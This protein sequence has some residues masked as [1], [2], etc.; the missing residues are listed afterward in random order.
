MGYLEIASAGFIWA[1]TGPLVRA[2]LEAGFTSWDIV[3]GRAIFSLGFM[4]SW[5][6][7]RGAVRRTRNRRLMVASATAAASA[8]AATSTM[9]EA[10]ANSANG[11]S[12]VDPSVPSSGDIPVFLALGFLA[13]VLS[14]TTYFYA[15]SKTS[16]AVA[17]TLNYTAPFFV[18]LISY[19]VY[20]EPM[21]RA[22]SMAL[23]GAVL[24][25]ALTSG[26][27]GPGAG[28]LNVN[29]LGVA[30]GL[31]S[32]LAYGSQTL[33]YKRVGT[34]Y[35]PITLNFWT[36]ALGAA[37]LSLLLTVI[38][39]RPPEVFA[40]IATA[41]PHTW[42]L[43]LLIG[44]GPG[45][46]AF[47]LFADGINKVEATR[48]SIVAMSEPVA[49]CLFGYFILNESLTFLQVIGVLLVLG[50]IWTVSIAGASRRSS[51]L[52]SRRAP[53]A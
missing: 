15:L 43:L 40:K 49:A 3:L 53:S 48:G 51:E 8:V 19:L 23:S 13:V 17:V 27:I 47:I 1:V 4:G 18:M 33:I 38:T 24:G 50:S 28:R 45:T 11:E 6:L 41:T 14:Q 9:A 42:L 10:S 30:A 12:Q 25:V 29:L 34:R 36:M 26:F 31:M 5:L 16:V 20:K 21:T 7:I 32:G 22:K 44:M 52:N 39:R 2:L 46:A 35:G 37:D